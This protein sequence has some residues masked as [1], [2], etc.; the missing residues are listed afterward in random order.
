MK[1]DRVTR[2][3]FLAGGAV[4]AASAYVGLHAGLARAMMGSGGM[5]GGTTIIDPPPG[6]ALYDIPDAVKDSMGAYRLTVGETRLSLNGTRVTL[7]TYGGFPRSMP[8]RLPSSPR[9]HG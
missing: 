3:E 6:S 4:A 5:G 9:R 2:R 1:R 8:C 7:L